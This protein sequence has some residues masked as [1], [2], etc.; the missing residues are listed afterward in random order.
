[1]TVN[2][3][4]G[5]RGLSLAHITVDCP[6]DRLRVL[7]RL[8]AAR[9]FLLHLRLAGAAGP[10][11]ELRVGPSG[12]VE[13]V[14]GKAS[15]GRWPGLGAGLE[16]HLWTGPEADL[17]QHH[18]ACQVE[19]VEAAT[20]D[21]L[22]LDLRPPASC[23]LAV[24]P[25]HHL[26]LWAEVEGEPVGRSYTPVAGP[27]GCLR[28]LVKVYTRGA[29]TPLLGALRPGDA[30]EVGDPRGSFDPALLRDRT[31]LL[32]LAAGTGL[33]PM[34]SLLPCLPASPR[35]ALLLFNKTEQDI[36]VREQLATLALEVEHVLSEAAD[37]WAGAR[38]RIDQELVSGRLEGRGPRP[39]VLVCGPPGFVREAARLAREGG[40][41][42]D[43]L[44]LFQ[45]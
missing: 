17:A 29:L 3:Y 5:T 43:C 26:S 14:L 37:D 25:G 19:A 22:L 42:E 30:V 21:T 6:G 11:A 41:A 7:V 33:T 23:L 15:P 2:V 44:H 8:P 27:E 31:G 4:T 24:P 20:H 9:A 32:L 35:P 1:M 16:G 13:V 18:R 38:G 40:I 10:G 12:K 36:P 28:L 39:L 45:G 34:L